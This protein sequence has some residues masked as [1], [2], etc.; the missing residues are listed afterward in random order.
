MKKQ[1]FYVFLSA[2]TLSATTS[3][4]KEILTEIDDNSSAVTNT[5]TSKLRVQ[6][7]AADDKSTVSYPV[8]VYVM[9][10][11]GTCIKKEMLSSASDNLSLT[12]SSGSYQIY[13]IG[14]VTSQ[15]SLPTAEEA[16][17]TSPITLLS[18]AVHGDLMTASNQVTLSKGESNQLTLSMTRKVML[19]QQ[20]QITNVPT[21]VD[22][23]EVSLYPLYQHLTL[24]GNY[25]TEKA[26]QTISLTQKSDGTTWTNNETYYLL[27]ATGEATVKVS[28]TTDG[29]KQSYSYACQQTLDANHQISIVGEYTGTHDITLA[30]TI[31]GAV[32]DTPTVINFTFGDVSSSTTN[33]P[34]FTETAPAANTIY[35]DCY[36]VKVD[37][38]TDGEHVI[39]TLIHKKAIDISGADRTEADVLADINAA[40]PD[41]DTNGISGWRLPTEE[42]LRA[43]VF[44]VFNQSFKNDADADLIKSDFY[45][46]IDGEQLLSCIIATSAYG[47][48]FTSGEKVRPVTTLRMKK[49]EG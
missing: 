3:C 14:G 7:R 32:W 33:D 20:L 11:Q 42:E 13:A 19:L 35:N 49:R 48:S 28:L 41:F 25:S 23:V 24:D 26:E 10:T 45:Y 5:T 46:Y 31:T 18:E 21:E 38:D 43:F 8:A 4:E 39:V 47:R 12:L 17:A 22:A 34:T 29:K 6:A 36:V 16:S 15:Y 9:N 44:G 30:G 27:P 40:L 37:D 2:A 1:L